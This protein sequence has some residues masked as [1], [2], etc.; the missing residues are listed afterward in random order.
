MGPS[1]RICWL[2][3]TPT[4]RVWPPTAL[5]LRAIRGQSR[6]APVSPLRH[7]LVPVTDGWTAV[8]S[9]TSQKY[10][11]IPFNDSTVWGYAIDGTTGALTPVTGNPA[12]AAGGTSIAADPA[13]R[14]LFV[15]DSATGDITAFTINPADGALTVVP[16]SPFST[17]ILAAQLATD[18]QGKFLY[19]TAGSTQVAAM[20]ITQS[21][22]ALAAVTGSPFSL[23]FPMAQIQGEKSGKFLLGISG[24]DAH[25]HVFQIDTNTGGFGEV[26]GSPFSTVSVPVNLVVYPTGKFVYSLNGAGTPMEAYQIGT[27]GNLTAVT[28][29]PFTSVMLD[30][31]QFDQSGLFLF[32]VG[33]GHLGAPTFAPYPTNTSSGAVSVSQFSYLGFPGA[34]FAVSD[35][36]NAP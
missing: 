6:G 2:S 20:S 26:V 30:E 9:G 33:A 10:L 3:P 11:Y 5:I 18:G 21:T 29:S 16:G 12:S 34:G 35:L 24:S 15:G 31:G 13:G 25:I 17:G 27:S 19:A 4:H 23:G 1:S 36:T 14:F 8:V 32:G 7:F 28:G 22:G